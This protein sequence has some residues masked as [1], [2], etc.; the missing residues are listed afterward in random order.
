MELRKF[1]ILSEAPKGRS[2]R[3]HDDL[4]RKNHPLNVSAGRD[5][6]QEAERRAAANDASSAA[7]AHPCPSLGGA[8]APFSAQPLDVYV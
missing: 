5:E 2:R 3:T 8:K 4:D 7:N 1:L 6:P